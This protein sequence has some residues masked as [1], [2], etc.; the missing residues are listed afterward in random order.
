MDPSYTTSDIGNKYIAVNKIHIW[1]VRYHYSCD[2]V[3]IVWSLWCHQQ[4]IVMSS[5][6]CKPS[7]WDTGSMCEDYHFNR[8]SW[9]L[10]VCMYS[11]DELFMC[12]PKSY[13]GV[14][15]PCCCAIWERNTKITLKWAHKQFATWVHISFYIST[16]SNISQSNIAH[17][18]KQC[19][20][21]RE[22]LLQR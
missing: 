14:Y 8:H 21:D 20:I 4:S 9:I 15:F 18:S 13:L 17:Y 10:Y 3:T 1:W 7:D 5:A 6:E 19:D 12:S 22:Y 11:C 16:I 2:V